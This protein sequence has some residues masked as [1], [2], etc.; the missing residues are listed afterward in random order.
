LVEPGVPTSSVA[1][2]DDSPRGLERVSKAFS[3]DTYPQNINLR[4]TPLQ[5][6]RHGGKHVFR[7][8]SGRNAK[9][10]GGGRM[11]EGRGVVQRGGDRG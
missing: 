1:A 9:K 6:P 2:L 11:M 5:Q 4:N 3:M 8:S 7:G 10:G